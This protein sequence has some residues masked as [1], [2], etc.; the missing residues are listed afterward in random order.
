MNDIQAQ[1]I[2]EALNRQAAK[3]IAVEAALQA[4]LECL[5]QA[6]RTATASAL[7][8]RAASAMQSQAQGLTP[9]MDR[10]MSL[11]LAALLE[12]AGEPPRR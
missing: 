3:L 8:L 7:R 2:T 10:T 6:A 9:D 4:V 12:A 11:S 1:R 5:P